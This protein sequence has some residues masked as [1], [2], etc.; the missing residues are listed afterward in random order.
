VNNASGS[1]ALT[2]TR[3]GD[4]NYN[5]SAPSAPFNVTLLKADQAAV[6]VT[7]PGDIT[8]GSTGTAAAT[9]G[10]GTGAYR[11][12]AGASNGCSVAGTT[13]SVNNASGSCAITG[14]RA[15][16]NNYNPSAP[17]APFAVTLHKAASVTTVTGGSFPY[18]GLAHAATATATG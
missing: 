9:G 16:D 3:G 10:S 5:P 12:S 18:D 11:F 15:G 14:T 17:S 2:A 1:C 8:Y 6:S 4:N 7:G 13:V